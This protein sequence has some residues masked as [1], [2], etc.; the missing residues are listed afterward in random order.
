MVTSTTSLYI[1]PLLLRIAGQCYLCTLVIH[2]PHSFHCVHISSYHLLCHQLFPHIHNCYLGLSISHKR[3]KKISKAK[4]ERKAFKQGEKEN[5]ELVSN[6]NS[7][8]ILHRIL[9]P[10]IIFDHR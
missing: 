1:S 6:S 8:A 9:T 3:P 10:L 7:I 5:K 4:E 2:I